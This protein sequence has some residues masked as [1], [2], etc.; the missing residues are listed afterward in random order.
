MP[1][2]STIYYQIKLLPPKVVI[3]KLL[4]LS[5]FLKKRV[6][7]G[8]DTS[9]SNYIFSENGY[10]LRNDV[11]RI[12]ELESLSE[13]EKE[14]LIDLGNEIISHKF[15][16]LGS[17]SQELS[18]KM[19][20]E[21]FE[22]HSYIP[23]VPKIPAVVREQSKY[24][25]EQIFSGYKAIPWSI[26]FRSG[27]TWPLIA[28]TQLRPA[29]VPGVDIKNPWELG[30]MQH[31]PKL[32]LAAASMAETDRNYFQRCIA[33]F[34]AQ[35]YD[36]R[37]S[38]PPGLGVQWSSAM[39]V[40][41]R[42]VN[43]LIAWDWLRQA[44]MPESTKFDSDL[45]NMA[46]EHQSFVLSHI[47]YA[48]GQPNNHYFSNLCSLVIIGRYLHDDP[49]IRN[50]AR[51]ALANIIYELERQFLSNGSNFEGSTHYHL[52]TVEMLLVALS[53]LNTMSL[54]E[55]KQYIDDSTF[56][57]N[58]N[59]EIT[60]PLTSKEEIR[61]LISG[62][63]LSGKCKDLRDKL[64]QIFSVSKSI[65]IGRDDIPRFGDED[66]GSYIDLDLIAKGNTK[67]RH[68]DIAFNQKSLYYHFYKANL[69]KGFLQ[70][71]DSSQT[72]NV[73][74]GL[75]IHRI[76]AGDSEVLIKNSSLGLYGRG[77]HNHND[78]LSFI[79][80]KKGKEIITDPGTYNYTGDP[81][82]R[83]LFRS[84]EYHNTPQVED[85][86]INPFGK[87]IEELFWF[88]ADKS[89][90]ETVTLTENTFIG[91]HHG[92]GRKTERA[93][94]LSP[95]KLLIKDKYHGK[96]NIVSRLHIHP[97]FS[98][99]PA[100]N[101][102]EINLKGKWFATIDCDHELQIDEYDFSPTYGS[103]IKAVRIIAQ[104]NGEDINWSIA[105]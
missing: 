96:G 14:R 4:R 60:D 32:A 104:S 91:A 8:I 72:K 11:F 93:F 75:G 77:G 50:R 17:G 52:F 3:K 86:Q 19:K 59:K 6:G 47:E 64:E 2:L 66:G 7:E 102:I 13:V 68:Y 62:E 16:L 71:Y 80:I 74:L 58:S 83:N 43:I 23:S 35:I 95:D 21:G 27:Y 20:I 33:E 81:E 65:A 87:S 92:F 97:L 94:L 38:C 1:S 40:G 82:Y 34:R 12:P 103:R 105:L 44:G 18:Y 55:R 76:A 88:R 28:G 56:P 31:L 9:R 10:G 49:Q 29:P 36:F 39:D 53:S 30:R 73:I 100:G 85:K 69:N 5:G 37:A 22:G 41:I 15:N 25:E 51:W 57:D 42:M 45:R 90:P 54:E 48:D 61:F 89:R 70:L 99:R 98:V 84:T 67:N 63:D 46:L 24:F 101:G 78:N 79:L 26:D